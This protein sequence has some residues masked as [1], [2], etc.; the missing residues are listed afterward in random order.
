M[1]G[2]ASCGGLSALLN[3]LDSALRRD[4]TGMS[5]VI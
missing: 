4:P 5:F 3:K 2:L 1:R